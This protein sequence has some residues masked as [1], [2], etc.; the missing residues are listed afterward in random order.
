MIIAKKVNDVKLTVT[1]IL[2]QVTCQSYMHSTLTSHVN[3][4]LFQL[5]SNHFLS[6]KNST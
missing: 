1:M 3:S 5:V 6:Q 4:N 2:K